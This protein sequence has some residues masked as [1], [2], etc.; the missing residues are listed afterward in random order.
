MGAEFHILF[1]ICKIND[2]DLR[3]LSFTTDLVFQVKA[4]HYEMRK[5]VL[6]VEFVSNSISVW[7]YHYYPALSIGELGQQANWFVNY[8]CS[9]GFMQ[10]NLLLGS[11]PIVTITA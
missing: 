2:A 8:L 9:Y 11:D 6:T 7:C 5:F 4:K 10:L 3:Y 1:P